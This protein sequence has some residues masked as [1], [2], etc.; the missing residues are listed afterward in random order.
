MLGDG[1]A[2]R[3]DTGYTLIHGY[4]PN[5]P[6]QFAAIVEQPPP[7][8]LPRALN[9]LGARPTGLQ[10]YEMGRRCALLWSLLL[11]GVVSTLWLLVVLSTATPPGRDAGGDR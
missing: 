3:R 11:A 9:E 4:F 10:R 1:G 5:A 6:D 8:A 7:S 2:S